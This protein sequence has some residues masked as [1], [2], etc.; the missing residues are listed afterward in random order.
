MREYVRPE[1]R[2]KIY[3][4]SQSVDSKELSVCVQNRGTHVSMMING[5]MFGVVITDVVC[6]RCPKDVELLLADSVLD[7]VEAH[8][9]SFGAYLF[10][11]F[12]G[13]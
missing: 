3:T 5:M 10:A 7:P 13:D 8:V 6:A 4:P 12:I 1:I 9:Y 2:D 11:S